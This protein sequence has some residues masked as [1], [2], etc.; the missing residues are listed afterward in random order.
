MREVT[1]FANGDS[2]K[3]STWSNVPY[4]FTQ[5]LERHNIKVNRIDLSPDQRLKWIWNLT[6]GWFFKLILGR[7]TTYSYFRSFTHYLDVKYRIKR[8]LRKFSESDANIFLT[9]SFSSLHLSRKPTILFCDWTYD[10]YFR[11][12]AERAPGVM[13]RQSIQRENVNIEGADL[14]LPLFPSVAKYM[15]SCYKNKNIYYLGNVI[16]SAQEGCAAEILEI[17]KTSKSIVF[18]G[19]SQYAAGARTLIKAFD[20]FKKECPWLELDLI[21]MTDD[22]FEQ[23]LPKG[24]F[25]HGYLSKDNADEQKLYYELIHKAKVFVNTTP[26]WGAFSAAL[27]AM[28]HYTPV[29]V[30]PYPD[31]VDTFGQEIDFG[32]Y[33]VNNEVESIVMGLR[34]AF[35]DPMHER[36]CVNANKAA[37][38]HTWDAYISKMLKK[39]EGIGIGEVDSS[40]K[41]QSHPA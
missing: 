38:E 24:V 34:R 37:K 4:F 40:G 41:L 12:F 6:F 16:N 11:Y 27:E 9:F 15:R 35:T 36:L 13:E 22:Y 25:C 7:K 17:K 20:E 23:P 1:V 8:A 3:L 39:I 10:Y 14:V 28:Y 29:M 18:I 5:T 30:T 21:G 2:R 33:C 26:K 31:F 32:F 19:S